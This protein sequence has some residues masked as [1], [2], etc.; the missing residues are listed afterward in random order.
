MSASV[1]FLLGLAVLGL[2][3]C[4]TDSSVAAIQPDEVIGD[5]QNVQ[6]AD[7]AHDDGDGHTEV[8]ADDHDDG[9]GHDEVVADDHDDGDGH[10]E[11]VADDHGE[12]AAETGGHGHEAPAAV[13]PDAP[14]MHVFGTEFGYETTTAE[15][16]AG[17]P[18]TIHF[19]NEGNLEHDITFEG[20]ED[21]GGIHLQ[22]GEE[23]KA[24][25][26]IADT[27]K[28]TYYCTVAGHLE[29]GMVDALMVSGSY[30]AINDELGDDEIVRETN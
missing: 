12:E 16:E 23:G 24:T 20:L 26:L 1:L 30:A 15:V 25:F 6:I 4:G 8:V 27:G 13:D 11:V 18:F 29:A 5:V 10:D 7:E 21:M 19:H 9:D 3:A 14:V 2:V 22:P 17:T 28:Y